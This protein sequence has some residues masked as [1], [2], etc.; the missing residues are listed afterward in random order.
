M[1]RLLLAFIA[2]VGLMWLAGW[3]G[4]ATPAQRSKALKVIL[5]YGAAGILLLLVVTGR[6]HWIF[7]ALSAAVPWLQRA[8][9]ARQ[10]WRLFKRPRGPSTAQ[11]S[12]V[13]TAYLRMT[14]DHDPGELSG[15]VIAGSFSGQLLQDLDSTASGPLGRVPHRGCT[16]CCPARSLPGPL[17]RRELE[18]TGG[19]RAN[20]HTVASGPMTR[21][22]AADILGVAEDAPGKEIRQAHRRL[23]QRL[24]TDRGGSDYLA[25]LINQARDTSVLDSWLP[26]V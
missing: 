18:S 15:E 22:E 21:Q 13:E 12:K 20:Q 5:L 25:T 14:L 2:L 11:A 17:P 9:M 26:D 23:I 4:K 6:I 1:I 19:H 7:A 10:A 24:H 3:L 16:V 8:M